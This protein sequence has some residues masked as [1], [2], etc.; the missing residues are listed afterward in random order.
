MVQSLIPAVYPILKSSYHLDFAQIGLITLTYQ[1]TASLLQPVVGL[2]TDHR[3]KPYSLP[4]G[5]G[6]TLVGPVA[7][8][9]CAR[10]YAVMLVAAALVGRGL[11]GVSSRIVA[12][13]AHGVGRPAWPGAIAVS[14]RRK[15]RL[16]AGSA[17]GRVHRAAAR[18]AQHRLVLAGRRCIAIVVLSARG[19]LVQEHAARR[20]HK[21]PPERS[22]RRSADLA[23]ASRWRLAVLI[24]LIFS[25]YFYLASLTSYYTFY[26]ISGSTC[27]CRARRSTCSSSWARWRPEP[28]SADRSA[29]AS[30]AST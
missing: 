22:P 6:F 2:Y 15:C 25:K 17:A 28:S 16:V 3:P 24:A 26:L 10:A 30:A 14:G 21:A 11:G 20:A 5:M 1:V 19:Q 7:C 4:V 18:A 13:G 12:R 9:R 29:T 27:R 23:R 8:S